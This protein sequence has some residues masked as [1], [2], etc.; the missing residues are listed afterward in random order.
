MYTVLCVI[1][2]VS[3]T[4]TQCTECPVCVRACACEVGFKSK[5]AAPKSEEVD[6]KQRFEELCLGLNLDDLSGREAWDTYE[7]ISINYTLEGDD[8][9]WLVCALY[10][11]CRRSTVPT[12]G[13]GTVEGNCVSLTRLLRS[14]RLSVIQFF[15]KM[16]KWEDMAN[17]PQQFRDKVE[18][19]ERNF[20]VSTVIFKKYQPIFQDL[21]IF[22]DMSSEQPRMPRGRKQRRQPCSYSDLFSFCWTLFILVKGNFPAISDDLV[23]S[24]HLLL[25]CLDLIFSNVLLANRRDLLNPEFTGLPENYSSR[26]YAVPPDPPCI[27]EK[28]CELHDGLVLEA[29]GIKEHWWKPHI[30]KLIEDRVLKGNLDK[31]V[32]LLDVTGF[33]LNS[34]SINNKYEEY[35]LTKGDFDERIFLEDDADEEIGTPAKSPAMKQ[36]TSLSDKMQ[37]KRN[38]PQY[39]E[40]VKTLCPQT[41]LTGRHYLKDKDPSVT[42]VSTATQT[43]SRLQALLG[44]CKAGP[45]E[46]LQTVFKECN[47]DVTES[48]LSRIKVMGETFCQRYTQDDGTGPPLDFAKRRLTLAIKMYYKALENI[49]ISEKK[50]VEQKG[51]TDLSSLLEHDVFHRS[52]LACCL[53]VIIFAYNSQKSFPWI[54]DIFEL[55]AFHFYKVIELLLRAE[56]CLS[57]DIVKHLNHVEEEILQDRAWRSD[58]PLWDALRDSKDGPPSCEDVSIT[59][60]SD[61]VAR[62]NGSIHQP[63]RSPVMHHRVRMLM[64]SDPAAKKDAL[65]QS[66]TSA[67]DRFSSPSPGSAKRRLFAVAVP[68]EESP[69]TATSS[70][71]LDGS[72]AAIRANGS[73]SQK[74]IAETTLESGVT[75]SV[76]SK[77][78]TLTQPKTK[79]TAQPQTVTVTIQGI[80]DKDGNIKL[81]S[82]PIKVTTMPA[83]PQRSP[84]STQNTSPSLQQSSPI[85]EAKTS[86]V[87]VEPG[88]KTTPTGPQADGEQPVLTVN[89]PKRTGSVGLFFRKVFHLVNVRL[90]DLAHKLNISDELRR[91]TWTCIEYSLTKHVNLMKDRHLDQMIMCAIYLMCKVT[92]EDKKFQDIMKAYRRQPQAQSSVYRSV[93][94]QDRRQNSSNGSSG[95]GSHQGSPETDKQKVDSNPHTLR[96]RS[97]STLPAPSS[98]APPTPTRMACTSSSFEDEDRGDL[99]TFYN[100]VYITRMQAFAL[101]FAPSEGSQE[102]LRAPSLSP[103]PV[104]R[105]HPASPRRVSSRHEVYISPHSNSIPTSPNKGMLYY[106]NKSPAKNLRDINNMI[107]LGGE[108]QTPKRVLPLGEGMESSPKRMC[109]EP[110]PLVQRLNSLKS[111]R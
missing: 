106:I 81:V 73:A 68:T 57:R 82:S 6:I 43:V 48:I 51:K 44:G 78:I 37:A 19:L 71:T 54:I 108:R 87:K 11:A 15:N 60:Q 99:I 42:P 72:K 93:L 75:V 20:N 98:S 36:A 27:I 105:T 22:K 2:H 25:C 76:K 34:K 38:M 91:K 67:R 4:Y 84:A 50:R 46:E 65:L 64:E 111:D 23:N 90:L 39:I 107:K 41:P 110:N 104:I 92:K 97:A 26:N 103:M 109:L 88:T 9:H 7:R 28:L 61:T 13:N 56:D 89:K 45:S 74:P 77:S 86:P 101:R 70:S 40:K 17:L 52:L 5:M 21:F 24:Y 33:E 30:H 18:R 31:L 85:A 58:S 47:Q 63:Y 102:N 3:S 80:K 35:V 100:S 94:L 49:I 79:A 83:A 8:L 16:K 69:S 53:E 1:D 12:V 62:A 10:V 95:S 29:K 96:M 66:P 59:T 32:G 55:P 14:S